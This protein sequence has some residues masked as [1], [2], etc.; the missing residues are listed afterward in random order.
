MS[1]RRQPKKRK[2]RDESDS[3]GEG[4]SDIDGV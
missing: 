1:G 4:G 2:G 3:E